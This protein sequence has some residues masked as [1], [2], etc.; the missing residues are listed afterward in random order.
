MNRASLPTVLIVDDLFG[1][2]VR[3]RANRERQN[4]CGKFLLREV[5]ASGALR[6]AAVE[7][8]E[9]VAQAVFCRGQSP[10]DSDVGDMVENDVPAVLEIVRSGWTDA[11]ARGRAPWAMV[12]LDLC[13]LTGH[14]TEASHRRNPGVPEGRPSDEE[15]YFGLTLLDAIHKEA[16]ELPIFILSSKPRAQ[17]SLQFSRRGALGFIDR[18][19]ADGPEQ[20]ADALWTHGLI[21]DASGGLVGFS[22]GL[23]L[24]LRE[25][26]RAARHR[27]N[28]LIRG[29]RGSGK[30]LMARFVHREAIHRVG[31]QTA[32]DAAIDARPFIVVNSAIF[33][34]TLFASE[35]FGIQARTA[36]GVDGKAGLIELAATGDLFLDEIGDMPSEVQAA[37][38]RALQERQITRVGGRESIPVDV[39]FVSATNADLD[40]PAG[41]FRPDLLDR[42]RSG[43]TIWLPPL[44]AR[45]AD[46]AMLAERFVREAESSRKGIRRRDITADALALLRDYEW[47]GNVRELRS[48]VFEAITRFPDV[49]HLVGEHLTIP[50]QRTTKT[51][52]PGAK[53][54][55]AS[56]VN[57]GSTI[58]LAELFAEMERVRVEPQFVADWGGKLSEVQRHHAQLI[59]RMLRAALEATKRRTP[60]CPS[61]QVLIH[62]AAKLATGDPSLT[63][64]QAADLFKRLLGPLAAELEG[65]LKDAYGTALRLRPRSGQTRSR[66]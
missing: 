45:T 52:V 14:V 4:L 43:G 61:G 27:E 65:D 20:L 28:M 50:S 60:E 46:V 41:A 10:I 34:P 64:S 8:R 12:L 40:D 7:V 54:S 58:S 16:P 32:E 21:P 66:Q 15:T 51:Q 48:V 3:G 59:A 44:R 5:D 9:A 42:L 29:E 26:R 56:A 19:D 47:P 24:A 23:L 13:F 62:P 11:L 31:A 30:E 38:L 25:G 2:D 33:T 63:A 53:A 55:R 57:A 17:V 6:P 37:V 39:R 49:E 35:L 1:R 36:T 22:L 18:G